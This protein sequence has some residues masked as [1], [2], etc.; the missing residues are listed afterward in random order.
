MLGYDSQ[1]DA[2]WLLED[3]R[4]IASPEL[5]PQLHQS[6]LGFGV[7]YIQLQSLE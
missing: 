1:E 3:L 7:P 6:E 4:E 2:D 5:R